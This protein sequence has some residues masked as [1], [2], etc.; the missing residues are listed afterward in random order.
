L[1]PGEPKLPG[2]A[3]VREKLAG[4]GVEVVGGTPEQF[5]AHIRKETTKWGE[6]VKRAGVKVD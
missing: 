1:T 4:L 2:W 6:V 5:A 3:S